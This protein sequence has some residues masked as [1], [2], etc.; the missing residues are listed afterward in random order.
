MDTPIIHRHNQGK[1]DSFGYGVQLIKNGTGRVI[2]IGSAVSTIDVY[3]SISTMAMSMSVGMIDTS[4]SLVKYGIQPG[5]Q[6]RVLI[7]NFESD[8][9][10]VDTTMSII[11]VEAVDRIPNSKGRTCVLHAT[12]KSAMINKKATVLTAYNDTPTN[13]VK[14]VAKNFLDI[15]ASSMLVMEATTGSLKYLPT[16]HTPYNVISSLSSQSL[17]TKYGPGQSFYF[18]QTADGFY[19]QSVKG[20]IENSKSSNN[21]WSYTL[22]VNRN[23]TGEA[24]GDF[25]RIIDYVH[26]RSADHPSRMNGLLESG[27]VQFNHL[28][29]SITISDFKYKDKYK[30][31]QTLSKNPIIDV[32]NNYDDWTTDTGHAIPGTQSIVMFRSNPEA[33]GII[34]SFAN[35]F[36]QALSQQMAFRQTLYFLHLNGNAQLRAGDLFKVTA[37]ELSADTNPGPDELM[38]GTYLVLNVHHSMQAGEVFRTTLDIATDGP[39]HDIYT[40]KTP[41]VP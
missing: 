3:E 20:I 31:M 38:T 12:D 8:K 13:I 16:N 19:Y 35:N 6:L 33:Y 32:K 28:N 29:R 22:S 7:F 34:D 26:H 25:Y 10:K 2:D 41:G 11:A 14:D 15:P 5:D 4:N 1:V 27:L 30:A 37:K 18:Y 17:S 24:S 40:E 21:V 36:H 9:K 39:V 23:M